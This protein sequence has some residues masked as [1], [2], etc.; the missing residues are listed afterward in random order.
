VIAFRRTLEK[1][2][3]LCVREFGRN[4]ASA[5][6]KIL[7]HLISKK[8]YNRCTLNGICKD[9]AAKQIFTVQDKESFIPSSVDWPYASLVVKQTAGPNGPL[10]QWPTAV[11]VF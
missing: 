3:R 8:F 11:A 2:Y 1:A 5:A 4:L 7:L 9:V 10:P 6:V